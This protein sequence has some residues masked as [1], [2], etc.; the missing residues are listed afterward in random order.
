[1]AAFLFRALYNGRTHNRPCVKVRG[2]VVW[3]GER[4]AGVQGRQ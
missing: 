4:L 2:L 1:V 3:N